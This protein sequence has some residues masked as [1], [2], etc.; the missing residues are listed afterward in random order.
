MGRPLVTLMSLVRWFSPK[1]RRQ[2]ARLVELY[3]NIDALARAGE[4]MSS[5]AEPEQIEAWDEAR[6]DAA[7]T[8]SELLE[9][10]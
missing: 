6:A 8:L 7:V 1:R 4:E 5:Y 10:L 2:R 9:D 3:S